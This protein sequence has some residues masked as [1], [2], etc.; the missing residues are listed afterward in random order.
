MNIADLASLSPALLD[1]AAALLISE[2]DTAS[3]ASVARSSKPSSTRSGAE[4]RTRSPR[5]L[6][7]KHS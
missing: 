2:F 3:A 5:A 7:T 1:S 6:T 4:A